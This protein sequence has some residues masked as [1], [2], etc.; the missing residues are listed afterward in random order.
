MALGCGSRSGLSDCYGVAI[1]ATIFAVTGK[2]S[3][4]ALKVN[5]P[6]HKVNQNCYLFHSFLRNRDGGH[7]QFLSQL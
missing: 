3:L 1:R 6:A 7:M 4:A 5:K 2:R